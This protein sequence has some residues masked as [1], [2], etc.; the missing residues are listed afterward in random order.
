MKK[1]LALLLALLTILSLF[2]GCGKTSGTLEGGNNTETPDNAQVVDWD[3][4]YE[5]ATFDLVRKYGF[6]SSKWDGSL[7]L[8]TTNE[9][10]V[11]GL[12]VDSKVTDYANNP[13]TKYFREKTGVDLTVHEFA[14]S[15]SDFSTQVSLM[16]TGGEEMP[17][18]L[19]LKDE[20]NARRGEYLEAGY[21]QNLAGYCLTD[22]YYFSQAIE[23]ATKDNPTKYATLMNMVCNYGVNQQTQQVYGVPNVSD[24]PMDQVHVNVCINTD[25]LKKLNLEKPTTL[26]ELYNVLVA[27]R[28]K[29]PNGNGKKDEIPMM[30]VN[31]SQGRALDAY[32]VSAFIQFAPSRKAMI[33]NGKAF[34]FH[35]Q[36]EYREGLKFMNKLVKEGL[37]STMAMT[38]S[39]N[40]MRNM[41]N[42]KGGPENAIVGICAAKITAD[43][44]TDSE[45][46][47]VY[48]PLIALKDAGYGRGGYSMF[49]APTAQTHFVITSSCKN[50]QLAF[51]FL[52]FMFSEEACLVQRWGEQGVDWD[53][54]ENTEF[55]DKAKGNGVLGGDARYVIYGDGNRVQSR[56]FVTN[57]YIDE[58]NLQLFVNP[59]S[60]DYVST[61]YRKAAENVRLQQ[62][63]GMPKEQLLVFLRTP[64]EDEQFHEYNADLSSI[65]NGNKAECITNIIDPAD[66]S[67]W[68]KY[69][70]DLKALKFELWAEFG[71]NSYD[72]QKAE[73]D[74]IVERFGK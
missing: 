37:I 67:V 66:D 73:L 36:N 23:R 14:G 55:K 13:T 12:R 10:L 71:Q 31:H 25:W 5:T 27:F 65:V 18:I 29:D 2:A 53:W 38:G 4:N 50:V 40:D 32:I 39:A 74:A 64:E 45:A 24:N 43:Y 3:G 11:I 59:D 34:S 63:V 8:T 62:S 41:L 19:Y 16:F 35:D 57:T 54:I 42:Y 69:L 33:E 17:D 6:G 70:D 52:D 61:I 20:G 44:Q 30:G 26:D 47:K 49:E 1:T 7:P 28:D 15:S 58:N 51:R 9:K 72:R 56:W 22:A 60:D 46:W 48:E 68:N 21:L